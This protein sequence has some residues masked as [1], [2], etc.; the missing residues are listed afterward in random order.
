[1]KELNN[2]YLEMFCLSEYFKKKGVCTLT[3]KELFDFVT[4]VSITAYNLDDYLDRLMAVSANRS[5]QDLSAQ[6]KIDEEVTDGV[7]GFGYEPCCEKICFLG[8]ATK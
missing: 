8:F 4:D 2:F 5:L 6:E 7:F 3:V 1:M